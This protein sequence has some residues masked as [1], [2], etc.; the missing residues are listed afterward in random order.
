MVMEG[1]AIKGFSRM[2][3]IPVALSPGIGQEVDANGD[4]GHGYQR[5]LQDVD[6]PVA[7]LNV[8]LLHLGPVGGDRALSKQQN[9]SPI[10]S[11]SQTPSSSDAVTRLWII[12]CQHCHKTFFFFTSDCSWNFLILFIF[13]WESFILNWLVDCTVLW[14]FIVQCKNLFRQK[15]SQYTM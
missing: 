12:L 1:M 5:L 14:A 15:D 10:L 13:M 6:D 2:W 8:C 7:R 3:M 4:G 9:Y 11:H